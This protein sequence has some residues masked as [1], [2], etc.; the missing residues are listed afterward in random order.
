MITQ[1]VYS[2]V[3]L[4]LLLFLSVCCAEAFRDL[5]YVEARD[6]AK[7]NICLLIVFFVWVV[8]ALVKGVHV[9]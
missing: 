1:I 4:T 7:A 6:K 5:G 2:C 3:G 8:I 9:V